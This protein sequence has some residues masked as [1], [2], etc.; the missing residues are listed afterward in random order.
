MLG[1]LPSKLDQPPQTDMDGGLHSC[2]GAVHLAKSHDGKAAFPF[3]NLS[4]F[5]CSSQ[6]LLKNLPY[7]KCYFYCAFTLGGDGCFAL[8]AELLAMF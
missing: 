1:A 6:E 2:P 5:S 7:Q 3:C 8:S 4:Y